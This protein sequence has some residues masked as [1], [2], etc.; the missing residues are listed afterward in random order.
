MLIK[1]AFGKTRSGNFVAKK[2]TESVPSESCFHDVSSKQSEVLAPGSSD[3][4]VS[5]QQ[6][7]HHSIPP[8]DVFKVKK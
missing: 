3:A 1:F 5:C 4:S 6:C 7:T 8:N 2:T